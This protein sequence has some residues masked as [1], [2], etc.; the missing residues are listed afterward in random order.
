[1]IKILVAE[2]ES[3]SRI[4]LIHH[5]RRKLGD[6]LIEVVSNVREAVDRAENLNP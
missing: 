2:D 3:L 4:T 5:L 6:A 1:M